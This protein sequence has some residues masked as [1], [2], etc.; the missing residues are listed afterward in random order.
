M[1]K[2]KYLLVRITLKR[3]KIEFDKFPHKT[4]R[5]RYWGTEGKSI[6]P[7][8]NVNVLHGKGDEK[9]WQRT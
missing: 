6:S 1:K 2:E 4:N 3:L 5:S 7:N 8:V 9:S